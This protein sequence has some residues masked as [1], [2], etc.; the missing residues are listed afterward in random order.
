LYSPN[1]SAQPMDGIS[2]M[3]IMMS[4]IAMTL[5]ISFE[6][7]YSNIFCTLSMLSF[8]TIMIILSPFFIS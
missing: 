5:R 3:A 2:A 6:F 7:I 1:Q 4:T 8:L